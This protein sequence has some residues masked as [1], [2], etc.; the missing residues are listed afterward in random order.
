MFAVI[1][2]PRFRLQAVLRWDEQPICKAVAVV[3]EESAT[4]EILE[5]SEAAE[6]AGV[7][8]G[9]SSTQAMARCPGIGLHRRSLGQEESTN[10]ALIDVAF[11]ATPFIEL[12]QP[13]VCTMDLGRSG[14][15][16]DE[17]WGE[18][19]AECLAR[20]RLQAQIGIAENPDLARLA[21]Q[22]ADPV[23]VVGDSFSFLSGLG[24][25]ALSPSPEVAGVLQNWG[26]RHL[27]E[28]TRLPKQ[29]LT[30]RLGRG[31]AELWNHAAGRTERV[32]KLV[33]QPETFKEFFE[34]EREIETTEP[35]LF[36][37]RRLLEQLSLRLQCIYQVAAKLTVTLPLSNGTNYQRVFTIPAPTA[38]VNTLFRILDTHFEQLQ[39]D[40]APVA[41]HLEVEPA[42]PENQQFQLFENPLR[43][44]NR[45]GETL[46]RLAA[47]VGNGNVGVPEVVP[48]HRADQ[49]RLK[50]PEFTSSSFEGVERSGAEVQTGIPLRRYRP[51]LP[52]HVQL[53]KGQ[54]AYIVSDQPH[55]RVIAIEG[56]F[57]RSSDWW[58]SESWRTEEWDIETAEGIY[59][60]S[61][62]NGNW[63]VEGCYELR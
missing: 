40:H 61:N 38:E 58:D 28:L 51:G 44:P 23:L 46:A 8:A 48:T 18:K 37:L 39:L 35:L 20:L 16:H 5:T 27:G 63:Q 62:T 2:L 14:I 43:D 59:R 6:R 57:L 21:A 34:F 22:T 53:M 41:L 54:P 11:S 24:I 15:E 31:A 42:K 49:F 30:E 12:T 47:V 7:H 60:V 33:R 36:I 56:P 25:N 9:M 13:G 55:G 1:Y 50:P 10:A 4:G 32:L 29:Q 52:A 45:F 17:N 26:I 3:D 19:M